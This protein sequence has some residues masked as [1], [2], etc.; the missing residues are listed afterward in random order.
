MK[1]QKEDVILDT[2]EKDIVMIRNE[3][4][5]GAIYE[6]F[7]QPRKETPPHH[8]GNLLAPDHELAIHYA[9]EFYGRRQESLML[10]IIPR[11]AL[12]E[13]ADLT[14]SSLSLQALAKGQGKADEPLQAVAVFAQKQAG[15][16]FVWL[17]D[18]PD[19]SLQEVAH[20]LWGKQGNDGRGNAMRLW[21]CSRRSIL[22]LADQDLL[23]PPLDRSYR[24]LDGY[25]IREKLRL[26]RQRAQVQGEQAS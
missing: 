21:L 14:A 18:I 3:A 19:K 8:G 5:E 10:W 11:T 15:Q 7:Q 20:T 13:I 4:D 23:Q 2:G 22:E 9:R 16:P 24:R 12:W 25:N 6:I 17:Q 26:A 1:K